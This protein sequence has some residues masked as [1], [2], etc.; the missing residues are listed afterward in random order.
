MAFEQIENILRTLCKAEGTSGCENKISEVAAQMLGKYMSVKTDALGNILGNTG[1]GYTV[2]LDA[3]MD[4]IGLVVTTVDEDGFL[5]VAKTGGSDLR[6]MTAAQ[7]TVHGEKDIYGVITSTPPHLQKKESDGKADKIDDISVDIGLKHDEAV[8]IVKP[9]DRITFRG[10]FDKLL[11][12]RVASPCID[13]RAGMAV[14][15]RCLEMLEDKKTCCICVMFSVQEETGGSGAMTGAFAI[16]PDEAL[17][18]DVTFASAPGVSGEKYPQLGC[19]PLVGYSP[20]LDR[21]ISVRLTCLAK[22]KNIPSKEEVMGSR[23]GTNCDKIQVSGKGIRTALLSVPIRNMHTAAE[24]ADLE[25][26][27]NTARLMAEYILERSAEN[28]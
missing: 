3:H 16:Q 6:V 22:E 9:G 14:I 12:N 10:P 25:D 7:V 8:K 19:G 21:Q 28:A 1:E 5:K 15:L 24:V 23:T 13:D 26:I 4:Q 17:A 2:M 20:V 18:C 11:G 27:E